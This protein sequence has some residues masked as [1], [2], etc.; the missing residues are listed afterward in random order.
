MKNLLLIGV[1]VSLLCAFA[2]Q[3]PYMQIRQIESQRSI[4]LGYDT[5]DKRITVINIPFEF[6]FSYDQSEEFWILGT[7]YHI[8]DDFGYLGKYGG[9]SAARMEMKMD[10]QYVYSPY[11]NEMEGKKYPNPAYYLIGSIRSLPR[12]SDIQDSL[13]HYVQYR[14][15][16]ES[17]IYIGSLA[18]FKARHPLLTD[19]LLGRDSV[20]FRVY[21]LDNKPV[22]FLSLPI[23]Y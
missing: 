11:P 10:G 4:R 9:W 21:N 14:K 12:H 1:T 3:H 23:E 15:P 5:I 20:M 17:F 6:E 16:G 19:R 7:D 22:D 8:P 2:Q 18:E 13:R